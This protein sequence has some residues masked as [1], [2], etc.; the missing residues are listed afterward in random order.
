MTNVLVLYPGTVTF[1]QAQV[2]GHR[3]LPAAL[4]LRLVLAGDCLVESDRAHLAD[5]I[6]VP[7]A[8][9]VTDALAILERYVARTTIHAVLAQSEGA[10]LIG[11]LI[12]AKLGVPCLPLEAAH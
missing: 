4:G 6:A 10:M 1:R 11:A 8:E 9:H 2:V 7:A 12:G 5:V 3:Q